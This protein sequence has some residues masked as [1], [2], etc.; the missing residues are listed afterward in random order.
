M[1]TKT[2]GPDP[3]F[4]LGTVPSDIAGESGGGLSPKPRKGRWVLAFL[5]LALV[6][7]ALAFHFLWRRSPALPPVAV[8]TPPATAPT[9]E[10]P[11]EPPSHYPVENISGAA[12]TDSAGGHAALP[13]LDESD[14]ITR[15]AIE[16]MLD[17]GALGRLLIPEGIIRHLVATVDGLPRQTLAP[18]I[19]PVQPAPDAMG[20][21]ST[22]RGTIIAIENAGRYAPYVKAAE[23]ID[24]RR[25]VDFYVRMYPLFQQAY[26]DLGYPNGYFNDRVV[27]VIDHLLAAPEPKPPLYL[28]QPHVLFEFSD[29]GL[30]TLSSGQK[31]LVRIGGDNEMRVKAKLRDIRKA[32]TA[33]AVAVPAAP[34]AR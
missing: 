27:T 6:A 12:T 4:T 7:G 34:T 1:S 21:T 15:E 16:K 29:P 23:T 20:T 18:R 8:P 25:L 32:L 13:A 26:V 9:A 28:S 3:E 24:T 14:L 19:L 22:S 2:F 33:E 17:V 11:V 30:E 5:V 31:I 10:A